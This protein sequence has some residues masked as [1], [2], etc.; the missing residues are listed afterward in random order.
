M[1][2]RESRPLELLGA[3]S[4]T[5]TPAI[6]GFATQDTQRFS[7]SPKKASTFKILAKSLIRVLKNVL[8]TPNMSLYIRIIT[9][10]PS[11][12]VAFSS[13]NVSLLLQ[14]YSFI[15]CTYFLWGIPV[16]GRR[17]SLNV[18]KTMILKGFINENISSCNKEHP[19]S[20]ITF[21]STEWDIER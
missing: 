12:L 10:C 13:T 14:F 18:V 17:S 21:Q 6:V 9:G 8:K 15:Q 19:H 4:G 1:H 11:P 20:Q 16:L 5:Q 2:F 3:L 7:A